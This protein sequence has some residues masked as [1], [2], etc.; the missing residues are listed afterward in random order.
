[1]RIVGIPSG[2]ILI[3][4]YT[5]K[6]WS[7]GLT[8]MILIRVIVPRCPLPVA[9]GIIAVARTLNPKVVSR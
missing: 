2:R 4:S 9:N 3:D 1:V 5:L 6:K 7:M 8:N